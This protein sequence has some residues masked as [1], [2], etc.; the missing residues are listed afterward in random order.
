MQTIL[1]G[2]VWKFGD[3]IDTDQIALTIYSRLPME[4]MKLHVLE[5]IRPE[6]GKGAKPGDVIIAGSNFGCGSS[7]E[8]APLAIKALGI[9]AVVAESF[10]RIFFRNSIAIGLP[11]IACAGINGICEDGDKIQLD[12]ERAEVINISNGKRLMAQAIPSEMLEVLTKGGIAEL[13]KE[14]K[15]EG[16]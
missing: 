13:L 9:G 2:K 7:R 11:A 5:R 6:F 14:M 8:T 12:I 15:Q 16:K 1:Q 4:E 10:A 3:N